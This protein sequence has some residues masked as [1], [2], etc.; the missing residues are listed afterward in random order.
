MVDQNSDTQTINGHQ[1][2]ISCFC[3]LSSWDLFFLALFK[4]YSNRV[5]LVLANTYHFLKNYSIYIENCRSN[6]VHFTIIYSLQTKEPRI[7]YTYLHL[8]LYI[9]CFCFHRKITFHLYTNEGEFFSIFIG[10]CSSNS[11]VGFICI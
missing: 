7:Q 10:A 11:N 3:H 4:S 9:L 8:L 1:K 5:G 2:V 6:L